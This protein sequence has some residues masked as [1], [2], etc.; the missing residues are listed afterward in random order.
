MCLY[1]SFRSSNYQLDLSKHKD[2]LST[3]VQQNKDN[4]E[5]MYLPISQMVGNYPMKKLTPLLQCA[6][7]L[8]PQPTTEDFCKNQPSPHLLLFNVFAIKLL[9]VATLGP[10]CIDVHDIH[11]ANNGEINDHRS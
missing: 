1:T 9:A 3:I 5:S 8:V 11:L 4:I 2:L 6:G 10:G 7:I